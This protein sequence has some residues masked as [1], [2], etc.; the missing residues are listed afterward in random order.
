MSVTEG[1]RRT[2]TSTEA[3]T[4]PW[5]SEKRAKKGYP[6][7]THRRDERSKPDKVALLREI[8]AKSDFERWTRLLSAGTIDCSCLDTFMAAVRDGNPAIVETMLRFG[9]DR[10]G[11]SF[12]NTYFSWGR[13]DKGGGSYSSPL[14]VACHRG[15]P[16]IVSVLLS[17]MSENCTSI[18]RREMINARDIRGRTPLHLACWSPRSNCPGKRH[19]TIR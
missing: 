17:F 15:S 6:E 16:V 9:K 18:E 14:H 2:I 13:S 8:S 10:G 5:R 1:A 11:P 4:M 19:V 7:S 12:M 3:V